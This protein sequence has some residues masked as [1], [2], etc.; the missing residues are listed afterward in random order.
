[1]KL[2]TIAALLSGAI[3]L[4]AA[5]TARA[6]VPEYGTVIEGYGVPGAALGA[7][8]AEVEAA[9]GEP[10]RCESGQTVGDGSYCVWLLEDYI[11]QGGEV[12]SQVSAGFRT[13]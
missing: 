7:T 11:G 5:L 9:Y 13:S 2:N 10:S 1:M 4:T 8:R 6:G 12:R 3:S